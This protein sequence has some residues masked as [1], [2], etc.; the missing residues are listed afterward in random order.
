[1]YEIIT[2]CRL[3]YFGIQ[4][5]WCLKMGLLVF[6][7]M[8]LIMLWPVLAVEG[9]RVSVENALSPPTT[10]TVHC[11]KNQQDMGIRS[12]NPGQVYSFS[13]HEYFFGV[14]VC[15]FSAAGKRTTSFDVVNSRCN[16]DTYWGCAWVAT[17]DGFYCQHELVHRW[18]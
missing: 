17:R 9:A 3:N 11:V 2:A 14:C 12:L 5:S 13:L 4:S 16:C 15:E 7:V 1:V 8:F 18:A 6:T 10:L